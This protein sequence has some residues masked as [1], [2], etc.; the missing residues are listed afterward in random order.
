[1]NQGDV[2]WCHFK[3]PDKKRPVVILTRDSAIPYLNGITVAWITPS[4]RVA[5]SEASPSPDD[6]MPEYC[7]AN[8]YNVHTVQRRQFG[9]KITQL[10]REKMRQIREAIEFALGYDAM[11]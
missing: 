5:P 3:P 11:V 6:G 2:Y 7:T 10:S 8:L 1:M 4:V 9:A